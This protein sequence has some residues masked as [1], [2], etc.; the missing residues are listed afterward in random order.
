MGAPSFVDPEMQEIFEGFLVETKELLDNLSQDLMVLENEP[1]NMELLNQTFRGFHTIKGTSAFMGFES[2][3]GI[4]HHAEDILNKLRRSELS[5]SLPIID[6]LLEVHDWITLLV[7]RVQSGNNEPV[8]YQDT[9]DKID[10][11]KDSKSVQTE[12]TEPKKEEIK[13]GKKPE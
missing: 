10:R 8:D 6:V 2:I 7:E 11:L 12:K 13:T 3:V 4:T 1:E 9:I 5:V